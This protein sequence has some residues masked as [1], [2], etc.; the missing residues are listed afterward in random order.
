MSL[1]HEAYER[2]L[3]LLSRAVTPHGFVAS[4]AFDH[5][6]VVWARDGL[7]S[8][9]G[10]LS[11]GHAP[12]IEGAAATLD[13]L[14]AHVSPLGQV[15]ALVDPA[16][17]RWDNGEGGVVD[18]TAWFVIVAGE[19]LTSTG[20]T[21]RTRAWWPTVTA[22]MRWLSY[23]D[24][25]GS[26]LISAAPS[27]DWMD[28]A[29]TRSGRTLHLNVLW[30]WAAT[31]H[32]RLAAALGEQT[33]GISARIGAAVDA[34]FWPEAGTDV[35]ALFPHGFAHDATRIAIWEAASRSRTHYLSHIVHAAFV[36]RCD[37]LANLLA[38]RCGLASDEKATRIL[39]ALEAA[40]DPYPTRTFPEP[41]PLGDGTG[42]LVSVAEAVIPERWRNRP[43]RYHNGAAWPYVGGFH[44]EVLARVRG[45]EAGR[46]LLEQLAA[47]NALADWSFPE[48]I[49][50]E[51]H[52]AGASLQTWNAATF[53]LAFAAC[54]GS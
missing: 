46:G 2:S 11:T 9:L 30:F 27:T 48:W 16:R 5:Y 52:P 3:D 37:T 32:E 13:T 6:A 12:L 40:A 29:L 53:V 43:G 23:Q 54:H 36:D 35:D 28:A 15:P 8:A 45:R 14:A 42:M 20:D 33:V 19:F 44:A 21:E 25:T 24:V 38:V 34:W 41:V 18:A 10:A 50:A 39:E 4:P 51:G 49:D 26:S 22:A 7:I 47:A 17:D 31:A 1:V